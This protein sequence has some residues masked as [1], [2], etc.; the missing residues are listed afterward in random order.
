LFYNSVKNGF[1]NY[2]IGK[3]G[4]RQRGAGR[5][6]PWIFIHNTDKAEGGLMVLFLV[7]FFHCCP[8]EIFLLTPLEA[9][10]QVVGQER[11]L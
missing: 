9:R 5:G 10:S 1:D 7:L 2:S 11:L 8:L 3:H 4:Y 6:A